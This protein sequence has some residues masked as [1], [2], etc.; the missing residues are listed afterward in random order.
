MPLQAQDTEEQIK[1]GF[2]V[3]VLSLFAFFF[4]PSPVTPKPPTSHTPQL[5]TDLIL[6]FR[7]PRHTKVTVTMCCTHPAK[8]KCLKEML[9]SK[10]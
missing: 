2:N 10:E 8:G 9:D 3:A 6:V 5:V 7:F 1:L 4:T